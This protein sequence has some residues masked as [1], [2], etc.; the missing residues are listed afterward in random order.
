MSNPN[1]K[2]HLEMERIEKV[3]DLSNEEV[4]V[5][6]SITEEEEEEKTEIVEEETEHD[7]DSHLNKY[8]MMI[9]GKY[10]NTA[11]D[12]VNIEK[13]NK[14]YRG[15]IE[16]YH[17]NPVPLK[18]EKEEGIFHTETYH[19]YDNPDIDKVKRILI[20]P[21]VKKVI[22]HEDDDKVDDEKYDE[23]RGNKKV[24]FKINKT[25]KFKGKMDPNINV[26]IGIDEGIEV[27]SDVDEIVIPNHITK[28]G[29]ECFRCKE[30]WEDTTNRDEFC[31]MLE[32]IVIP[33]SVSTIGNFAFWRCNISSISISN[34]ITYIPRGCFASCT[35]LRGITIPNLVED[36]GD[37][38]FES[39]SKLKKITLPSS[40]TSLGHRCFRNCN[41]LSRVIFTSNLAYIG[42]ECFYLDNIKYF[43]TT[44]NDLPPY[45]VIIPSTIT[46][47]G[48]ECFYGCNEMSSVW[49]DIN[50]IPMDCFKGCGE[51]KEIKLT[52]R[53]TEL[54]TGSFEDCTELK[55]IEIPT[56]V[57]WIGNYVFER[58]YY[59]SSISIPSTITH[60]GYD[61]FSKCPYLTRIELPNNLK[62]VIKPESI[63]TVLKK[64]KWVSPDGSDIQIEKEKKSP[65]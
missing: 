30:Y 38:A 2:E 19:F 37:D 42:S 58:C 31:S 12:L 16:R 47:L 7:R 21:G 33:N 6:N 44:E 18:N 59:L 62:N 14:E 41:E 40:V 34:S 25:G 60:L 64:I 28:I 3:L 8:S 51:I 56:S 23:I 20:K 11:K 61:C 26:L 4:R 22:I 45:S 9:V 36:I 35:N 10:A 27:N 39:C 63:Q 29:E 57:K 15:V 1:D 43:Y 5:E 24:Q 13:T 46:H 52:T 49:C 48:T 17:F 53:V 55:S 50:E 54:G 65:E 32:S